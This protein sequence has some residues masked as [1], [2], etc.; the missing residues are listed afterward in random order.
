M[1]SYLS[2]IPF[3]QV[4]FHQ[5]HFPFRSCKLITPTDLFHNQTFDSMDAND[6]IWLG[7]S[8]FYYLDPSLI[9]HYHQH[10]Y[11]KQ[12]I[13]QGMLHI[14][15]VITEKCRI[16]N[17]ISKLPLSVHIEND[18]LISGSINDWPKRILINFSNLTYN[19]SWTR[20]LQARSHSHRIPQTF[21]F[22]GF[23]T[24]RLR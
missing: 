1:C 24:D 17:C 7:Q 18:S 13:T 23:T 9:L 20:C 19:R 14:S 15:K 6:Q 4:K 3:I 5:L 21:V 8:E 16:N 12:S 22:S 10:V 2:P 11:T